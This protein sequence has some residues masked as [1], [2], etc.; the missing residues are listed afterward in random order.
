MELSTKYFGS[1]EYDPAGVLDFPN[2]LYG[3]E[4]EKRFLLLP[5]HGSDGN[6]LCFQSVQTPSLAFVAMNPFSL[7]SDYT[8]VLSEEELFLM[9]V[10]ESTEL[11]YYVLCAVREP[12][13]ESTVNLKC[14]VVVN[15]DRH[16]AAQVIL[17]DRE[18]QMRH[19]LGDFR[20]KGEARVC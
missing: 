5:F 4:E 12:V 17:E 20:P 14:P 19:R 13:A 8:P 3:F 6:L 7:K 1:I 11:C 18:Y 16:L 9:G 15:P 2:G 10:Q